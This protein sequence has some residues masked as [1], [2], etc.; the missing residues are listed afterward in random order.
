MV[1]LLSCFSYKLNDCGSKKRGLLKI[2]TKNGGNFKR[3]FNLR[4][5]FNL[6]LKTEFSALVFFFLC[7]NK[8]W[9]SFNFFSTPS[10]EVSVFY[11]SP[12]QQNFMI[13]NGHTCPPKKRLMIKRLF[14]LKQKKNATNKEENNK[15]IHQKLIQNRIFNLKLQL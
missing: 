13:I 12:L 1:F 9:C 6:I 7:E 15:K 3:N 8:R 14:F 10:K 11:T 4:L 5:I 2:R